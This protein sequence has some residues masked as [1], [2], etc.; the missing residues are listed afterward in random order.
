MAPSLSHCPLTPL[1]LS[2]HKRVHLW[3]H[4]YVETEKNNNL[5]QHAV[6]VAAA[7]AISS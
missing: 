1:S 4:T 5:P 7:A 6:A 2:L 3:R